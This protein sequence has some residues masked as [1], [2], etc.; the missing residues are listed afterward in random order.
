M[1]IYFAGYLSP[2]RNKLGNA[3]GRKWRTLDVLAVYN[4]R[5]RNPRTNPQQIVRSRFGSAASIAR[6]FDSVI[7]IGLKPLCDGTPVPERSMFIKKNWENF[8][9][10]TPG[11]VSVEY[12]ELIISEGSL[13]APVLANATFTDP[14]DV[15]V[16][17]T[18]TTGAEGALETD[19]VRLFVYS[20]EAGAGVLGDPKDREVSTLNVVVPAYMNGHRVHVWGF[21]YGASGSANAGKVSNS[22][23]LGSGTIQ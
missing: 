4:G 12:S 21:C 19:I 22:L 8:I 2:I 6:A 3:V 10:D 1:A 9:C 11:A 18:D 20:P 14:M 7:K 23:Y 5:P 16:A 13:A 17:Q 15:S